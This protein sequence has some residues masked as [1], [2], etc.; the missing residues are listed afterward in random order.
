MSTHSSPPLVAHYK[1]C[2][3]Y[4]NSN[5]RFTSTHSTQFHARCINI[6]RG[7]LWEV[8]TNG[9]KKLLYKVWN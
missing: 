6:W 7:N 5:R 9:K 2:G 1:W 3:K 4:Y 8:Y